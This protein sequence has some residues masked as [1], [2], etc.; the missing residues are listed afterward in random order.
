MHVRKG[1]WR[2]DGEC[3]RDGG[4]CT[5]GGC[6]ERRVWEEMA[7]ANKWSVDAGEGRRKE[8]EWTA[9]GKEEDSYWDLGH[10]A[11]ISFERRASVTE[12]EWTKKRGTRVDETVV[13]CLV[14][15]EFSS[16]YDVGICLPF[17]LS[18]SFLP[19]KVT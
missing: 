2:D 4:G 16:L 13:C 3:V 15:I 18:S 7:G 12:P 11:F 9:K 1:S 6:G 8:T 17:P 19:S 10:P 14:C 5:G